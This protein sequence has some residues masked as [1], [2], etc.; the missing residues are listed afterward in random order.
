MANEMLR[1]FARE[2]GVR[3]WQIAE[4]FGC[5]DSN[6]SRKLRRPLSNEDEAKFMQA[7]INLT[8]TDKED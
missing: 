5:N 1:S 4:A 8:A 3:L 2:H 7:V 6:L